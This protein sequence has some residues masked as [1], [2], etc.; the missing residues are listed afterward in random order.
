[1]NPVISES[2][3]ELMQ[4]LWKSQDGMLFHEILSQL[5]K[6]G[7]SWK[8]T[9]VLTFLA[10]LQEKGM[11]SAVK[12]GRSSRYLPCLSEEEYL[13]RQTSMFIDKMYRGSSKSL[14]ACLLKSE[15]ISKEEI[16]ELKNFW[17][18]EK[19]KHE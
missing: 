16:E 6:Q 12:E 4:L 11:L 3:M 18:K 7:F 1:M 9:T 14:V 17:Q 13:S 5:E 15:M 2:E 19:D 8:R 10:R